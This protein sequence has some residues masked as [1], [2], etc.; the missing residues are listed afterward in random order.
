MI[1]FCKVGV[2]RVCAADMR[3]SLSPCHSH[4][5]A[6]EKA[7]VQRVKEEAAQSLTSPGSS[8]VKAEKEEMMREEEER[9]H[10]FAQYVR[11]KSIYNTI[12]LT[13]LFGLSSSATV[14]FI[15]PPL[16]SHALSNPE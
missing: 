9:K 11:V 12:T 6:P 8:E 5:S 2:K 16:L 13:I 7:S 4:R 3:T 1:V 14:E 15:D 10:V